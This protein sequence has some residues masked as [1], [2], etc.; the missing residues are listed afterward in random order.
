[1]AENDEV[2]R[3]AHLT[4]R[5]DSSPAEKERYRRAL[6][7]RKEQLDAAALLHNWN[8]ASGRDST[9]EGTAKVRRETRRKTRRMR[10]SLERI[11]DPTAPGWRRTWWTRYSQWSAA[12]GALPPPK[13][14]VRTVYVQLRDSDLWM[15]ARAVVEQNGTAVLPRVGFSVERWCFPP[16]SRVHCEWRKRNRRPQLHAVSPAE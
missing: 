4:V 14:T 7:R 6:T 3:H 13:P 15:P 1:M 16:G 11:G 9:A 8:R 2:F 12:H 10:K 5:E